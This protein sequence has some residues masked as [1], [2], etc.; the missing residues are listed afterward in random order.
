MHFILAITPILAI[1]AIFI[2]WIITSQRKQ[3]ARLDLL[4][5]ALERGVPLDVDLVNRVASPRAPGSNVQPISPGQGTRVAGIVIIA[6]GAGFGIFACFIALVNS[7]GLYP[8]LGVAAM[9]CSVGVGLLI[10]SK[11]IRNDRRGTDSAA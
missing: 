3:Q 4:R 10:A 2:V 9:F 6:F 11:T 1:A 8:M 7:S 5:N